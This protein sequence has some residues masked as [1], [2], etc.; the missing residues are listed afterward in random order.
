MWNWLENLLQ[1]ISLHGFPLVAAALFLVAVP[2]A[3]RS[4]WAEYRRLTRRHQELLS[5][6]SRLMELAAWE[7]ELARETISA[8]LKRLA[9]IRR[10]LY[11]IIETTDSLEDNPSGDPDKR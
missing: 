11:Q 1:L 6:T 9:E 7:S 3:L 8:T 10:I 5:E 2:L 4:L